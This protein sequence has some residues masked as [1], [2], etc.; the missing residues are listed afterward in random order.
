[1]EAI[2]ASRWTTYD[3][4]AQY[5]YRLIDLA[6]RISPPDLWRYVDPPSLAAVEHPGA[7][8]Y[9][10]ELAWVYN[11]LGLILC[12]EGHMPDTYGV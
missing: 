2:T 10:D 3:K 11:D 9:A 12:A 5:H 4:Y 1:M 6:R 8:L 7:P